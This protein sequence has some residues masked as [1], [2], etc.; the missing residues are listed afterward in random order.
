METQSCCQ[1]TCYRRTDEHNLGAGAVFGGENVIAS[2]EPVVEPSDEASGGNE[3]VV[4]SI[5]NEL[6]ETS[7]QEDRST[8]EP[9]VETVN[10]E[11]YSTGNIVIN[12]PCDFH[13]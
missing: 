8:P 7:A 6:P 10:R 3:V 12:T 4:D 9:P 2:G 1:C 5:N 13:W 11:V